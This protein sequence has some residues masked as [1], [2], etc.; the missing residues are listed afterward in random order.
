MEKVIERFV[1]KRADLI[2]EANQDN[3]DFAIANGAAPDRSTLFRYGNLVYPGHFVDPAKRTIDSGVPASLGLEPVKQPDHVVE[4]LAAA[5][6]QGHDVK[7][8]LAGEGQLRTALLDRAE[9]LGVAD[10]LVMPGNVDQRRLAQLLAQEAVVVSPRTGRAL[11]EAAL[12]GAAIVADDVDWQGELIETGRT[13]I[14]VKHGDVA[15]MSKAAIDLLDDEALT[16]KLGRAVRNRTLDLLDPV[17]LNKHERGEYRK[18][19][20]LRQT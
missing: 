8:V 6:R 15:G 17:A 14:L 16:R 18:L 2:A 12:A 5:R 1:F 13:G 11:T 10:A 7:A 4:V 3:L 9:A 20:K 19:L